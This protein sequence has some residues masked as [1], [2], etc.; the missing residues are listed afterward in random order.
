MPAMRTR[1][2]RDQLER[3]MQRGI[4]FLAAMQQ[5]SGTFNIYCWPHRLDEHNCKPDY[6][7]FQ[8]AQIAYCLDFAQSE[9]AQAIIDGAIRFLVANMQDGCVWRYTCPPN[10]DY[11]APD[12]DDTS[13]ISVLLRR[14]EVPVPDNIDVLLGNRDARGL[15]YTWI[16]PRLTFTTRAAYWRVALRQLRKLRALYWF[17]SV[18]ECRPSDVDLVVNANVLFYL[19]ERPET[20]PII[21][22][23]IKAV[24]DQAE[25]TC[26]KY[27]G[28]RFAFY[29]F[30]SRT[31]AAGVSAF[32]AVRDTIVARISASANSDGTIGDHILH[33]ALA[34]CALMDWRVSSPVL[35]NAIVAILHAGHP[36]GSWKRCPFY[37]SGASKKLAWGCEEL[38]AAFCLE[39]LARYRDWQG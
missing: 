25:E 5:P 27:Y 14:H 37:F 2:D 1:H 33:T 15:F 23:L 30:V 36:S 26:D 19:G 31:R 38:T 10:P 35:D 12:V 39:A 18:T 24:E 21:R 9:K 17:Y 20:R 16:L 3:A 7:T 8:T 13:I 6:S 32:E 11:L 22:S 4:D 34:A 28:S 29:Y